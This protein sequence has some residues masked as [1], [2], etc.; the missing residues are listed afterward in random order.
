[1][2]GQTRSVFTGQKLEGKIFFFNIITYVKVI[3]LVFFRF[4]EW[5]RVG[6]RTEI[7]EDWY[8]TPEDQPIMVNCSCNQ[9]GTFAVLVDMVDLEVGL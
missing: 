9:L 4:G 1:M 5:S 7:A 6:C 2:L 8:E 3:S